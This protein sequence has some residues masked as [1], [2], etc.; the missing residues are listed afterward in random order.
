[1]LR[2]RKSILRSSFINKTR[3][4]TQTPPSPVSARPVRIRGPRR[5]LARPAGAFPAARRCVRHWP[6]A[7]RTRRLP[8]AFFLS[9][10]SR[11]GRRKALPCDPLICTDVQSPAKKYFA[12]SFAR[13]GNRA[14]AVPRSSGGAL[15]V[16]TN[17]ERGMRW[18]LWVRKTGAPRGGR[19]SRGV[20]MP[21]RWY[22]ACGVAC[23]A[24]DG[25]NK[26][27]LTDETTKETVKPSRRECR[28]E[29]GEPVVTTLACFFH[30]HVR[31]RVHL[32]IR[33]SL[34]PL[35][36]QEGHCFRESGRDLCR[37]NAEACP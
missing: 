32:S 13:N 9:R 20:P 18:T 11:K 2:G 10:V 4:F 31:L 28:R 7:G 17:V 29:T 23:P 30:L 8:T 34:R 14:T 12:F 6:R 21:R 19:R 22:Q 24:G 1:V 35:L 33:H 37:G 3:R 25:G 27:R 36:S 16:V 15:R 26:A 5:R